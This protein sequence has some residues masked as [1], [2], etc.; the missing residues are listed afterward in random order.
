MVRILLSGC[1]G[2]MG[3]VITNIA[4]Y[5]EDVKIVAGFDI[6]DSVRND[7][8]VFTQLDQC[9]VPV[10]VIVDFSHPAAL[11]NVL[12]YAVSGKIPLIVA[13]T[14]LSDEQVS[15]LKE[16]SRNIPIL[17]SA[18]M[19]LGVNLLLELVQKAAKLLYSN[20][21]IEIVERHHNQKID[22]PSGTALALAD[23][24][25]QALPEKYR[26]V[27]DRHTNRVK[28]S[29]DEIGIHAIRGGNIAGDHTVI[30][31]GNDEIIELR[32]VANS[33]EIFGVGALKAAVFIHDKEPN[34][35]SMKDLLNI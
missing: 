30:F 4:R 6:D 3:Q 28:R 13:T 2:K 12:N 14:G 15:K 32:H 27:Y 1:N 34:F 9:N 29:K 8:P 17:F 7:Y 20:F 21:D 33:K 25:N 11:L 18:N 10:D 35:Y 5:R 22:A 19:S 16:Y 23:A 26:Y 24:I 31:A